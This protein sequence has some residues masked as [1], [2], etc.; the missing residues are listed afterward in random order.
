[1][2]RR[3]VNWDPNE[4]RKDFGT[5]ARLAGVP[6][7]NKAI[8]I[9][10][11]RMPHTPPRFPAGKMAVYVFSDRTR[12]LKVGK[13]GPNTKSRYT[14]QH[15][16]GSAPSTLHRFLLEDEKM[17][18]RY[19]LRRDNVRNWIKENTDRVNFVLDTDLGPFVLALLETFV[20]CRL[21][22]VYE[23]LNVP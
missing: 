8:Q 1:M 3:N 22:P 9:E 17:V 10:I 14:T 20:Q 19:G 12:T 4:V 13:A 16:T 15:Y 6:V 7:E 23:H 11:L 18:R 2:R 21:K 5:V